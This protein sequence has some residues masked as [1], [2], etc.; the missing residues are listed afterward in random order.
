[1]D[2]REQ[3]ITNLQRISQNKYELTQ[4]EQISDY[5]SLML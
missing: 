2:K 3:L 5:T 4:D 1:M